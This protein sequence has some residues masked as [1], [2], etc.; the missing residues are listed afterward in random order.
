MSEMIAGSSFSAPKR[1]RAG[2]IREAGGRTSRSVHLV[3]DV[4][5]WVRRQGEGERRREDGMVTAPQVGDGAGWAKFH[6]QRWA[7]C[8]DASLQRG[9]AAIRHPPRQGCLML[10]V[11]FLLPERRDVSV[12]SELQG[13]RHGGGGGKHE[14]RRRDGLLMDL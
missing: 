12:A 7:T 10:P 2:G 6:S 14:Q 8:G 4:E 1:V 13:A 5:G 9:C 11:D 3:R